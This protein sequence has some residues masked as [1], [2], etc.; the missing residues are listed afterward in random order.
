MTMFSLLDEARIT[1][2]WRDLRS[3]ARSLETLKVT[4]GEHHAI[5]DAIE[6]GNSEGAAAAMRQHLTT[7]MGNL[8]K[9]VTK[10]RR[11]ARAPAEP[12]EA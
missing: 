6:A 2:T 1:Q 12:V 9:A 4:T 7:L 10:A 11:A 8:S 3:K 5:I